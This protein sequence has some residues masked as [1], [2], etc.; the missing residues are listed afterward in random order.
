M[1]AQH[2][3]A[4]LALA[5]GSLEDQALL[6]DILDEAKPRY[7]PEVLGLHWL[8]ATPFRYWPLPGGSRFRRRADPGV[9]Y[10]AEDR[11]TA[12]AECGSATSSK[13]GIC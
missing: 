13:P 10:G 4:T 8:L 7:P 11:K 6:E 9:F 1:E 5:G 3:V 2:R 12:C